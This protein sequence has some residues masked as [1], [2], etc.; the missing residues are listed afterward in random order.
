MSSA[1][2][3]M[4]NLLAFTPQTPLIAHNPLSNILQDLIN[5]LKSHETQI[6]DQNDTIS[7]LKDD[8]RNDKV[9]FKKALNGLNGRVSN[10][11]EKVSKIEKS[12]RD[13]TPLDETE[14]DYTPTEQDSQSAGIDADDYASLLEKVDSN[15]DKLKGLSN[16]YNDLNNRLDNIVSLVDNVSET[17]KNAEQMA[18]DAGRKASD[19]NNSAQEASKS[20]EDTSNALRDAQKDIDDAKE[21]A[22]AAKESAVNA[23]KNA[24]TAKQSANDASKKLSA[25]EAQINEANDKASDAAANSKN[26]SDSIQDILSKISDISNETINDIKDKLKNLEDL[27][28]Q[29]RNDFDKYKQ[30]NKN[31]DI[32]QAWSKADSEK[33]KLVEPDVPVKTPKVRETPPADDYATKKEVQL[34]RNILVRFENDLHNLYDTLH[35]DSGD[36]NST[37]SQEQWAQPVKY[38]QDNSVKQTEQNARVVRPSTQ[39]SKSKKYNTSDGSLSARSFSKTG[40]DSASGKRSARSPQNNQEEDISRESYNTIRRLPSRDIRSQYSNESKPSFEDDETASKDKIYNTFAITLN[41]I[42]GRLDLLESAVAELQSLFD[43]IQAQQNGMSNSLGG[44][45]SSQNTSGDGYEK[46]LQNLQQKVD[47]D[48]VDS[49]KETVNDLLSRIGKLEKDMAGKANAD[50]TVDMG[51]FRELEKKLVK[52][53]DRSELQSLSSKLMSN[54]RK[55][56]PSLSPRKP[57]EESRSKKIDTNSIVDLEKLKEVISAHAHDINTLFK[58]KADKSEVFKELSDFKEALDR[59]DQVKADANIVARKAEREYVDN[60]MDKLKKDM[61]NFVNDLNART[62]DLFAKDLEFLRDLMDQKSSKGDVKK[63]KDIIRRMMTQEEKST[64]GGLAGHKQFRCLSCNRVM[65]TMKSRPTSMNFSQFVNHLPNP[66][67]KLH[68]RKAFS[69]ENPNKETMRLAQQI[70]KQQQANNVDS[71]NGLPPLQK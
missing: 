66:K 15:S 18:N 50:N 13:G 5:T 55:A 51:R 57:K 71:D 33:E 40:G 19:A 41:E 8:A 32:Q 2:S 27:A 58:T 67:N 69:S 45:T 63:M 52:K 3:S 24:D 34:L 39:E 12:I 54:Q 65:D 20:A 7:Q 44:S 36:N 9:A 21:A 25:A 46:V 64:D 47:K 10:L 37:S 17:A 28:N 38:S 42:L 59:L 43:Q 6:T 4:E 56:A 60:L 53:V 48:S 16:N 1:A 26:N 68:P 31:N 49:L 11:E 22:N 23:N 61:E 70:Q 29:T 35:Q 62:S 14:S 30:D